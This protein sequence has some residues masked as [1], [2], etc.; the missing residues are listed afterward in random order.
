[1]PLT[2][3][4]GNSHNYLGTVNDYSTQGKVVFNMFDSIENVLNDLLEGFSG[5]A[6]TPACNKLFATNDK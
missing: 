3:T 4:R 5:T 1:M 2:A 6:F